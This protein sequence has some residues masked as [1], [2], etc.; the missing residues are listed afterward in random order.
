MISSLRRSGLSLTA[1]YLGDERS[2]AGSTYPAANI[3]GAEATRSD[4][5]QRATAT[6][7]A[8]LKGVSPMTW[9]DSRLQASA[10]STLA[11]WMFGEAA[12]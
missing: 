3:L 11:G 12:S 6:L 7:G 8:G 9:M 1:S 5:G 10:W 4:A 2:R